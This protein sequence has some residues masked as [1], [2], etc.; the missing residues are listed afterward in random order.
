[1]D[2]LNCSYINTARRLRHQQEL[3]FNFEL[4]A[5]HQ[6]LLV[7]SGESTGGK[8]RISRSDIKPFDDVVRPLANGF[9]IQQDARVTDDGPSIVHAEDRI[10]GEIEFKQQTAP[11][12]I[13]RDVS[14]THLSP[15]PRTFLRNIPIFEKDFA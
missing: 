5:D 14:N 10:L 8:V 9:V 11:M 15:Q 13:F 3:R 2:E 4:S 12:P 6:L 7:A 1:M